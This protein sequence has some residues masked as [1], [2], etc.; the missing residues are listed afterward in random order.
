MVTLA[1]AHCEA[2]TLAP[3][4]YTQFIY[5]SLY[6]WLLFNMLPNTFSLLGTGMI[7]IS[8]LAFFRHHSNEADKEAD[9]HHA[10]VGR[11]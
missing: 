10:A 8:I 1:H 3:L 9:V 2:S 11:S 5:A 4:I 6:S 7:I